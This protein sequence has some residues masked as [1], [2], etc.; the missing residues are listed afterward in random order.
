MVECCTVDNGR[1]YSFFA[2]AFL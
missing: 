1:Y 2:I